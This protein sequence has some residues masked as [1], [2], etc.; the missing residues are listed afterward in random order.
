MTRAVSKGVH[1]FLSHLRVHFSIPRFALFHEARGYVPNASC[2]D[3]QS[4]AVTP[5]VGAPRSIVIAMMLVR[6]R[7]LGLHDAI[8][9]IFIC[10]TTNFRE[11]CP[12]STY[13][14]TNLVARAKNQTSLTGSMIPADFSSTRGTQT[15]AR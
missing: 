1:T 4:V 12:I 6:R 8:H 11:S 3:R 2:L 9:S 15:V 14:T 5:G 10:A 7:H 13:R